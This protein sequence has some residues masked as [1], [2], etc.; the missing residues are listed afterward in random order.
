M[1]KTYKEQR[2]INKDEATGLII[3]L[4]SNILVWTTVAIIMDGM[5]K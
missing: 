1:H 5:L 3:F 2:K 4:V